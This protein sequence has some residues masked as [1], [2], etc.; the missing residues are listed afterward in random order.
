MAIRPTFEITYLTTDRPQSPPSM[1]PRFLP[2]G[3]T[4]RR[5]SLA[6]DHPDRPR[7]RALAAARQLSEHLPALE[8]GAERAA[9]L[10][11]KYET[12]CGWHAPTIMYMYVREARYLRA[13]AENR[14]RFRRRCL[15][16][17][18]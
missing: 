18:S 7:A 8:P 15:A 12:A 2:R 3:N 14:G 17:P 9:V 13:C 4:L 16:V 11:R 10:D 1:L 6:Q 5:L